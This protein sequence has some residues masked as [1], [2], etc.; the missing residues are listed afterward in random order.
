M[1]TPGGWT[2]QNFGLQIG[3]PV[4]VLPVSNTKAIEN[5]RKERNEK[6]H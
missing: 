4:A 6:I 5:P 3:R 2:V 1:A